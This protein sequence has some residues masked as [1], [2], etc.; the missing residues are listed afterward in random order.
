MAAQSRLALRASGRSSQGLDD[1]LPVT[2]I[3]RDPTPVNIK[4]RPHS[5]STHDGEHLTKRTRNNPNN[6]PKTRN[7]K[8]YSGKLSAKGDSAPAAEEAVTQVAALRDPPA[9]STPVVQRPPHN[10][11]K[12][13]GLVS[14][15]RE[16]SSLK[17]Q[18]TTLINKV[19]K[20]SLRS[21]GGSRFK[22][23]LALYFADYD[24]VLS[25]ELKKQGNNLSFPQW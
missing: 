6:I 17:L 24:E 21:D 1:L 7:F 13:N 23:E 18:N 9:Q 4:K 2:V 15:I 14:S 8:V 12:T 10:P 20:R 5:L 25:D 3:Q 19:D 16:S 11:T 22:S